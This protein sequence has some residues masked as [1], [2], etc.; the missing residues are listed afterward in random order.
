MRKPHLVSLVAAALMA[1]CSSTIAPPAVPPSD[2]TSYPALAEDGYA[3]F[4]ITRDFPMELTELRIF[5][6][7]DNRMVA[8]FEPTDAIAMPV[9]TVMLS[10]D[11]WPEV[12]AARRVEQD[13]GH[14]VLERVLVSQP[15][16][17][18]YQIWGF[19]GDVGNNVEHVHGVM[20]FVPVGD[21][22]TRMNWTY[23]VKP[24]AGWKR[25][26]VQRFV[27]K[28]IE[29]FLTGSIDKTLEQARDRVATE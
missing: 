29:P 21:R 14:F 5:L 7:E 4:T 12:G 26:L 20:E 9:D 23:K 25:P 6:E 13:D 2:I 11:N 3:A 27:D 19:T 16:R 8:N 22:E 17:F 24:D 15:D 28:E 1:A 10:G 18:E